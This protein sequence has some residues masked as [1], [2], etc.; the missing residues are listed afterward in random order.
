[1]T[2]RKY[3]IQLY[4][5]SITALFAIE[6]A[7]P[8]HADSYVVDRCTNSANDLWTVAFDTTTGEAA[9]WNEHNNRE[10]R[11]GTY[12]ANGSNAHLTLGTMSAGV[13]YTTE[14]LHNN[15]NMIL[16]WHDTGTSGRFGCKLWKNA[17]YR[18]V[19]WQKYVA[20]ATP[21]STPQVQTYSPPSNDDVPVTIRDSKAIV[22][23]SF[24][25]NHLLRMLVD[26]GADVGQ[27]PKDLA[28][29]LISEGNTTEGPIGTFRMGDDTKH[30]SRTIYVSTMFLGNHVLHNVQFSVEDAEPLLGFNALQAAGKSFKIDHE[31]GVLSFGYY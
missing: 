23:A 24:G 19:R 4:F 11:T 12:Y 17:E 8:A 28:N 6:E 26:T 22:N 9:F 10:P 3:L 13:W 25:N 20:E 1:M 2:R 7:A 16:A 15:E 5:V 29:Q 27:I 21:N 31:N 18:P 30:T 14:N